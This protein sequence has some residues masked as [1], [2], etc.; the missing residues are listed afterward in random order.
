MSENTTGGP[1][2]S[3]AASET[4]N[5]VP[6]D[7]ARGT[8]EEVSAAAAAPGPAAARTGGTGDGTADGTDDVGEGTGGDGS[9]DTAQGPDLGDIP[10]PDEI[11]EA[12]RLA[13]DH[14]FGMVDPTWSGEGEPPE[15]AIV[16]RW[17]SG[18]DGEIAEWQD[19]PDYQP[20]PRALD[21]PEPEDDVD[22]AVQ[23]AATG[24][25]PGEAVPK[26]L[27]DHEV[28]VLTGPGGEPLTAA[29]PDGNAV[30]PV[31]TSPVFLHTCGRFGYELQ[32]VDENLLDRIP[33]GHQIYV[34]PSGPVSMTVEPSAV[35][36][37]LD[38]LY[39]SE[40]ALPPAPEPVAT[41]SSERPGLSVKGV[42]IVHGAEEPDAEGTEGSEGSTDAGSSVSG[43]GAAGA[44]GGGTDPEE[45]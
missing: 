34:N 45:R 37:A 21:W 15:W 25:G 35:R 6:A 28:A 5:I 30:I 42:R 7:T 9:P 14:W 18:E 33:D 36:E 16:G 40:P 10:V 19:N 20:S 23:L 32:R 2:A 38:A 24:Y 41:T 44:D 22:R 26:A 13:P 17:R 8:A 11:R 31:F 43:D 1:R 4:E 39:A 3:D 29:T 27:L 12:G